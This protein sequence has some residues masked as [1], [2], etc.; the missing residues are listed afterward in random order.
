[1]PNY[2]G[3]QCPV[4]QN[5][6]REDDDIVVCP[7]CGTPYHRS[8]YTAKGQCIN[9]E[10]HA[11]GLSWQDMHAPKAA[12][13]VCP[14]CSHKNPADAVYCNVCGTRLQSDSKS[15]DGFAEEEPHISIMMPDGTSMAI[16]PTD[17]CCGM[18]P[19]ENF[20]GERLG[21]VAA[22]VRT[23]TFYYI[24]R[25]KRF[26]DTGKRLSVNLPGLLFPHLYFANRKMWGLTFLVIAVMV[27]CSIPAMFTSLRIQLT[28]EETVAMYEEMGMDVTNSFSG[29]ITFVEEHELLLQRL[30]IV[31]NG[32]QITLRTLLCVFANWLYYRHTLKK[33]RQMRAAKVSPD[34]KRMLLQSE[35]GT[36]FLNMIGAIA[37]YYGVMVIITSAMLLPFM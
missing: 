31:G 28:S 24:P 22:F 6:F 26:Q 8:C 25:F 37:L 36:N 11:K 20:G 19:N 17:P 32:I 1:M 35:G 13:P 27:L 5:N 2:T 7:D 30:E 3:S 34:M 18:S 23:N 14:N 10:L 12:L 21:D 15:A 29:L 33:V 9:T 16:D 4:C